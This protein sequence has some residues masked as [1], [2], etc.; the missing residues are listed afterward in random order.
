MLIP[1]AGG[2]GMGVEASN[3][4]L[5]QRAM[6]NA[7]DTAA[8]A[9]ATNGSTTTCTVV[10]DFCHEAKAA[11][12]RFGYSDGVSNVTV[13][14]AYLTSGCPGSLTKCYKVTLVKNLS[15]ELVQAVGYNGTPGVTV[16]G[17]H[18][19]QIQVVAIARPKIPVDYCSIALGTGSSF[20]INGG[21]NVNF[22]GCDL[23]S[24]GNLKC[25]GANSDTGVPFGEAVGTSNCGTTALGGQSSLTDP[26]SGLSSKIPANPCGSTSPGANVPGSTSPAWASP[27][28]IC[29]TATLSGDVNITTPGAELIINNGSLNLNGHTLSTSGSGSLTIIFSGAVATGKTSFTQ[30][31]TGS[32]TIDIAAP[33]SGTFSGVAIMDNANLTGSGNNMNWNYTGNSPTLKVQG[34]IYLPNASFSISGAIDLHSNGLSCIGVVAQSILVSGQGSIFANDTQGDTAACAAAGLILPT[35]PNSGVNMALVQ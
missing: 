10:G 4:Y 15:L 11:A 3:W 21:P 16:N 35:V 24:N 7:A 18:A 22:A 31:P 30:S 26:F 13:T 27:V 2:L 8:I 28:Q 19:Q 34:L 1:L 5:T 12:A 9:A 25:N 23:F 29:G 17:A 14:P 32:G 6:Q 33:S 20:T